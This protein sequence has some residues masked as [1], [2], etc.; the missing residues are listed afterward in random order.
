MLILNL[1][2]IPVRK[3]KGNMILYLTIYTSYFFVASYKKKEFGID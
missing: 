1:L 3:N 2:S